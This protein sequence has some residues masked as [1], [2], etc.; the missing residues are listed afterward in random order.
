MTSEASI[1]LHVRNDLVPPSFCFCSPR[2]RPRDGVLGKPYKN[3]NYHPH[4][5]EPTEA[6]K[7]VPGRSDQIGRGGGFPEAGGSRPQSRGVWGAGAPQGAK[8]CFPCNALLS[9][10]CFTLLSFTLLVLL[11][12]LSFALLSL[13]L[14]CLALFSFA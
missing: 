12:L 14:L 7:V 1:I 13:A 5:R 3:P 9:L 10:L 8:N 2:G 4:R 11:C 6:P